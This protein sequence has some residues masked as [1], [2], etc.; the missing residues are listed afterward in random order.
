VA[1]DAGRPRSARVVLGLIGAYRLLLSPLVGGACRY[2]PSCSAYAEEAVRQHGAA[3]GSWL[4][5]KRVARCHPFGGFGFDP[6]PPATGNPGRPA[7]PARS[8]V[9]G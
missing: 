2:L 8:G 5:L 6:V 9:K 4:A 7:P 3:R 1:P